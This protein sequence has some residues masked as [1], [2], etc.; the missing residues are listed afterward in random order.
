M[1]A[2]SHPDFRA[3]RGQRAGLPVALLSFDAEEFDIP[4]EYGRAISPEDQMRIGAAGT[5]RVLHL[6][7]ELS[8]ELQRPIK[9]TFFFTGA[10]ADRHP[11]LVRCAL[12]DGHE[13]ASHAYDHGRFAPGDLRRSKLAIEAVAGAPGS[14]TGFRMPRMAPCEPALIAAAGYTYNSS[15]HPTWLPGRYN[16]FGHP[17]T[18]YQHATAGGPLVQLPASVSPLIRWPVFWLAFK[19]QP[20]WATKLASSACLRVDGYAAYYFHP[21]EFCDLGAEAAD[22]YGL[23]RFVRRRD[24]AALCARLRALVRWLARRATFGTYQELVQTTFGPSSHGPGADA[25]SVAGAGTPVTASQT[26]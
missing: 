2:P 13:L 5:Q 10:L 3:S 18:I 8:S 9:S 1:R 4:L 25:H 12:A 7:R 23:P 19:N 16:H 20:L 14:V 21:W 6:L 26:A 22:G 24:G 15:D 11:E 17:R